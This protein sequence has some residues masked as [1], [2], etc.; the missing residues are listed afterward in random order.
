MLLERSCIRMNYL[1]IPARS[2]GYVLSHRLSVDG[3]GFAVQGPYVREFPEHAGQT[4]SVK[5]VFH[6]V[7]PRRMYVDHAGRA[8]SDPVKIFEDE[9]DTY[10]A[11]DRNQVN[12]SVGGSSDGR[13]GANCGLK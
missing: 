10:A 2:L 6:Q 9:G 13:V 4:A 11:G 5:E 12:Y 8:R 3:Q 1:R 7:L